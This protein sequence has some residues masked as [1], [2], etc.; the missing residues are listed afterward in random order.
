MTNQTRR[1][2]QA[3]ITATQLALTDIVSSL[4]DRLGPKLLALTVGT[5]TR[6]IDRWVKEQ[7][8][9]T[10]LQEQQRLRTAY[11]VFEMLKGDDADATIRAWFMGM[12][13]QLDD[14]SPAEALANDQFREVLAAA[15]AFLAGG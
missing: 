5:T 15:R 12:N 3:H 4:K 9:P 1:I 10:N 13:P 11:Q 8:G 2:T 7:T 6:S 14:T